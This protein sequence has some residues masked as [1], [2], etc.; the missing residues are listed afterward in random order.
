MWTLTPHTNLCTV[1]FVHQPVFS[2]NLL[3][4]RYVIESVESM[5][6]TSDLCL[7]YTI[8]GKKLVDKK[9]GAL[10]LSVDPLKE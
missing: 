6:L 3:F 2:S 1:V 8:G 10:V 9:H 4:G 5:S 7:C